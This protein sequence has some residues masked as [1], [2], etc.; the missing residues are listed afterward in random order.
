MM[1][2][3]MLLTACPLLAELPQAREFPA[4]GGQGPT[5]V[6][7]SGRSCTD[8]YLS[9]PIDLAAEGFHV[10][11]FNSTDLWPREDAVD[12]VARLIATARGAEGGRVGVVAFSLG[13]A[14]ALAVAAAR[15]PEHVAAVV[16]WYPATNRVGDVPAFMQA[17]RVPTLM[18]AGVRDTYNRCCLI[19]TAREMAA[20][21]ALLPSVPFELV[22]YPD[23]EHGWNLS[24]KWRAADAA[25]GWR[26]TLDHLRRHLDAAKPR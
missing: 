5:V 15:M 10:L 23:A 8:L 4:R 13:G 11:L 20:A 3:A 12:V 16:A 26:R 6:V 21:A 18:L 2:L 1:F 19:E 9:I 7:L 14:P 17:M 22:E 24:D 25:D